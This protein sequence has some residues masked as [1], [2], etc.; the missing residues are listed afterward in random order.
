MDQLFDGTRRRFLQLG[1]TTLACGVASPAL[2]SMP[3]IKGVKALGFHNLHT[4]ERLEL[5]YWK[6]GTYNRQALA[7]I[8]HILRDFRSGEAWPV[9][10]KLVD[11]LYDLQA[12]LKN[13]NKIEIISAYRS[14]KTNA[15]LAR[16]SDGVATNSYHTKGMAIDIRVP[17]TSLPKLHSVALNMRRGG[18]GYYP[19]SQF[20]HVDVG[21]LRRW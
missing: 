9:N 20:V 10:L 5:A 4:D 8:A 2:A 3:R 11:M 16:Y 7:R 13:D 18:V 15:T 17:G 1:L 21:P 6:N 12:R 14:P 19:D